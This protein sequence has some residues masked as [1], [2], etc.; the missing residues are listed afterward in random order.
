MVK[1]IFCVLLL[2]FSLGSIAAPEEIDY[3]LLFDHCTKSSAEL[4]T[5]KLGV[6]S[7]QVSAKIDIE[8]RDLSKKIQAKLTNTE[9]VNAKE[10]VNTFNISQQSWLK[11]KELQCKLAGE[12]VGSVMY[13][14]CPMKL[15]IARVRELREFVR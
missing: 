11:Y 10:A 1:N 15:G 6:C 13:T 3:E 12:Y 2:V 4:I 14:Y 5:G 9:N 7:E 8:L